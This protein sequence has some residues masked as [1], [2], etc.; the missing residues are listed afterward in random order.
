MEN[1]DIK[2]DYGS[3]DK[4]WSPIERA[5]E[6]EALSIRAQGLVG[7]GKF[8]ALVLGAGAGKGQSCPLVSVPNVGH[9]FPTG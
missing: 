7:R 3:E 4:I 8:R 5:G 1:L 2:V 9:Q 6:Q